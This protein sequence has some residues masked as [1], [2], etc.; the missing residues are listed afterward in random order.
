MKYFLI[1]ILL[2]PNNL[3]A[4]INEGKQDIFTPKEIKL[5]PI[6][7]GLGIAQIQLEKFQNKTHSINVI[8]NYINLGYFG[9]NTGFGICFGQRNYFKEKNGTGWFAEPFVSYF[10]LDYN[11]AQ[12]STNTLS[13]GA[14][15]G[16]KWLLFNR[17]SFD[18][19]LGPS[20]NFGFLK[21][22]TQSTKKIDYWVGP[23]NGIFA[24]FGC[25]MGYR[26]N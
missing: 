2:F 6:Y 12:Q 4:Q 5:N 20:L 25:S 7:A 9:N 24:R 19:Y 17:L 22:G 15:L 23:M 11:N 13:I 8:A 21:E 16:R 26:F 1:A 10:Y 3:I 18:V 14:V